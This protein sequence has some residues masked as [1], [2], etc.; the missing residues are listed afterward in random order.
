MSLATVEKQIWKE[1]KQFLNNPK[2][3]LKELHEWSTG[4]IKAQGGEVVVKL[5]GLGV[6]IAVP[7]SCDKRNK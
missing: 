7:T 4:G 5:P 2:M 1:A 6:N 3:K